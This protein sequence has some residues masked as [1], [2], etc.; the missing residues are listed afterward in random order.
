MPALSIVLKKIGE[1]RK[2]PKP[3]LTIVG[4]MGCT[5]P[6]LRRYKQAWIMKEKSKIPITEGGQKATFV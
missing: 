3:A 5:K 2:R 4:F 1:Q 6:F